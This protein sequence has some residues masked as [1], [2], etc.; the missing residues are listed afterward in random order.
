M[1]T[2]KGSLPPRSRGQG[3]GNR[4]PAG[5]ASKNVIR[6]KNKKPGF[7][8][9]LGK[10]ILILMMLSALV[11]VGYFLY[12]YYKLDS[13]VL[14]TGVDRPVAAD[15]SAKVKPLTMLLLGTD[16]RPK[17]KSYLTDVIMVVALNPE[18]E[19]ATIVSLPR[20]TYMELAGYKRTKINEYYSRFKSKED[21]SGIS[22]EDEMKTMMGKYL[23]V[24]IDYVT[25]L[26]FQGFR[27]AVDELGGVK[28]NI[29]EDMCYTD[30]A[31][32]TD[33]NLKEGPAELN[34]DK[35]LDYV[36]YRKSNCDPKTKASDDFD[37]NRRQSEVLHSLMDQMQ[38]LGGVVKIGG[39]LDAINDNMQTDLEKNQI[40]NM[41]A[42][43][44]QMSK[45]NVEF[46][47]VTGTWRSPY[48]YINEEELDAAKR[49]LKDRLAGAAPAA[50]AAP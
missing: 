42:A 40:K 8:A 41:I 31:D 24:K 1:S 12:L 28:V 27:G 9:R 45:N 21:T 6:K 32:G 26:N 5:Q 13:G 30:S 15:S 2:S 46:K 47:P 22:A 36:R 7:M 16:Y 33:I 14:D 34:G 18:T 39:V 48:V 4:R 23:D 44:W 50:T 37:R 20:D 43:Y 29:S 10:L 11:V 3:G 35:A 19:S 25:V 17:H 49:S 38:S